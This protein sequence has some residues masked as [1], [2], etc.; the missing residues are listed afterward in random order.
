MDPQD[1]ALD[2]LQGGLGLAGQG[3][4]KFR[5]RGAVHTEQL[6]PGGRAAKGGGR[7]LKLY[8]HLP[9]HVG[10]LLAWLGSKSL[11]PPGFGLGLE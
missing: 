10:R 5:R 7:P 1:P 9:G 6:L 11:I 3:R 2:L 8:Q 4:G